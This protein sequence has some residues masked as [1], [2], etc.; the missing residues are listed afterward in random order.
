MIPRE[1]FT[2]RA[3][4]GARGRELGLAVGL[5]LITTINVMLTRG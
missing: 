1:Q 5:V 3:G 2:C 4:D